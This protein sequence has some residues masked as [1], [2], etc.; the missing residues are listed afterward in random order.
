MSYCAAVPELPSFP[1]V[2]QVSRSELE[3][4]SSTAR[5]ATAVGAVAS[6]LQ[7]IL[8]ITIGPK[9]EVVPLA[10]LDIPDQLGTSFFND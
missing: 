10:Q 4:E 9:V 2:V 5:L 6:G 7:L 8:M 3:V 1:G